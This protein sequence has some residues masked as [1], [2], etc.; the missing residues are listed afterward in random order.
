MGNCFKFKDQI[1]K[2][3]LYRVIHPDTGERI[4][5][6]SHVVTGHGTIHEVQALNSLFSIHVDV[7]KTA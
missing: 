5:A 7:Y 3:L 2:D 6:M 4:S 1:A